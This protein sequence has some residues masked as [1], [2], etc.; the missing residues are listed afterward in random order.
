MT[1]TSVIDQ[2]NSNTTVVVGRLD[3][4][5]S[6][7]V[8]HGSDTLLLLVRQHVASGQE[9]KVFLSVSLGGDL[10]DYIQPRLALYHLQHVMVAGPQKVLPPDDEQPGELVDLLVRAQ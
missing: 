3:D 2:L 9:V 5:H 4:H 1:V 10:S 8:F 6:V 7:G